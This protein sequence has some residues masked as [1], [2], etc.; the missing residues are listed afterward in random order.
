MRCSCCAINAGHSAFYRDVDYDSQY[1]HGVGNAEGQSKPPLRLSGQ[2]S[3]F[4]DE[5]LRHHS[6]RTS[7]E[8]ILKGHYGDRH[9]HFREFQNVAPLLIGCGVYDCGGLHVD[10][11]IFGRRPSYVHPVHSGA[12]LLCYCILDFANCLLRF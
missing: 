7:Y 2:Y 10:A 1:H 9:D 6:L 4:P 11:H 3:A 12:G 5:F 8:P